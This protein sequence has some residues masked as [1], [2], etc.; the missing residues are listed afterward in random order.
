MGHSEKLKIRE[1]QESEKCI[2]QK[3]LYEALFIPEG[4]EPPPFDVITLKMY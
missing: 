2:L 4:I 3:L 1:L